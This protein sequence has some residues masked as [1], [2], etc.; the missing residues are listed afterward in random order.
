[1]SDPLTPEER[2][3]IDNAIAQG[4]VTIVPEGKSG[5]PRYIWDKTSNKLKT[6]PTGPQVTFDGRPLR[7]P[8]RGR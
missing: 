3:L 4:R 5:K 2:K 8:V 6:D 7:R 1:M